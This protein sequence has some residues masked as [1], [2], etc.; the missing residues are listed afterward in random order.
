MSTMSSTLTAQ[1]RELP[2]GN[3]V[4]PNLWT[5]SQ[6]QQILVWSLL[7]AFRVA[8]LHIAVVATNA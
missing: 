1:R 2:C 8:L 5:T 4:T 7:G 6:D 3:L